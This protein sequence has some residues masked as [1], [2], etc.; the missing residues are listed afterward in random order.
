MFSETQRERVLAAA[1]GLGGTVERRMFGCWCLFAFGRMVAVVMGDDVIVR[2]D[3]A[4]RAWALALPGAGPFTPR[5]GMRM[6]ELVRLPAGGA[7]LR[8]WLERAHRYARATPARPRPTTSQGAA[9]QRK[10]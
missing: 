4:S 1:R 8:A 3:P 10:R 7:R 5:P 9:R 2:L 6:R